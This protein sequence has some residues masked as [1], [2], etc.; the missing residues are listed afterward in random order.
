MRKFNLLCEQI[1]REVNPED[2]KNIA[3]N[4]MGSFNIQGYVLNILKNE[5]G[6][7]SFQLLQDDE[8]LL[9][10]NILNNTF[11]SAAEA[12]YEGIGYLFT[13]SDYIADQYEFNKVIADAE[14]A[15]IK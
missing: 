7:F 3:D 5:D 13:W 10:A 15:I 2:T 1:L 14:A 6:T 11:K 9:S 4:I 8:K 12:I